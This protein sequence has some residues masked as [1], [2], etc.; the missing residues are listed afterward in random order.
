[1]SQANAAG[2][3]FPFVKNLIFTEEVLKT[4]AKNS[5]ALEIG[6]GAPPDAGRIAK[7]TPCMTVYH[8]NPQRAE[9]FA[10][11]RFL[12]GPVARFVILSVAKNAPSA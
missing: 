4:F 7:P 2:R 12:I 10:H 11:P 9:F 5:C 3:S 1:V 6:V 8:N